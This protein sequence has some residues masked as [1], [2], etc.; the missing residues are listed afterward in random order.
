VAYLPAEAGELAHRLGRPGAVLGQLAAQ[1]EHGVGA[2]RRLDVVRLDRRQE[3]ARLAGDQLQRIDEL[4]APAGRIGH[5]GD[6]SAD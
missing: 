6:A 5:R 4:I 3:P 2:S 1:L